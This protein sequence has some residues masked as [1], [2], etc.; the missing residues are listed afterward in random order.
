MRE[1]VQL[2]QST[3]RGRCSRPAALTLEKQVCAKWSEGP[4]PG[5][6]PAT[7]PPSRSSHPPGGAGPSPAGREGRGEAVQGPGPPRGRLN[8]HI[9]RSPG[10]SSPSRAGR[11]RGTGGA[12]EGQGVPGPC[13]PPSQLP[14]SP[15]ARSWRALG[16]GG[17]EE[18]EH[19]LQQAGGRRGRGRRAGPLPR[20]GRR[21]RAA[22]PRRARGQVGS[23]GG[24]RAAAPPPCPRG[25]PS[26]A[27]SVDLPPRSLRALS[28]SPQLSPLCVWLCLAP[29][30]CFPLLPA[31]SGLS[32]ASFLARFGVSPSPSLDLSG[33][34]GLGEG[35]LE[36]RGADGA[37]KPL[38]APVQ[39]EARPGGEVGGEG[40]ALVIPAPAR[41]RPSALRSRSPSSLRSRGP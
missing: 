12:R 29:W 15:G 9:V 11:R 4:G 28:L 39:G 37:S 14:P 25:P 40:G 1:A 41:A 26:P 33:V 20:A 3:L 35:F 8:W 19:S 23:G 32:L 2:P 13:A 16:G 34:A 38:Q 17:S 18:P 22:A 6:A 36:N 31:L 27:L 21:K 24:G 7:L 5:A 10:S 30:V